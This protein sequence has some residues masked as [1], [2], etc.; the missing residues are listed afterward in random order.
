MHI[1][2]SMEDYWSSISSTDMNVGQQLLDEYI[3]KNPDFTIPSFVA[4]ASQRCADFILSCQYDGTDFNCCDPRYT[5]STMTDL[6]QCYQTN[7]TKLKQ[8]FTVGYQFGASQGLQ[9]LLDFRNDEQIS[10]ANSSENILVKPPFFNLFENGFRIHIHDEMAISFMSTEVISVS[11]NNKIAI[12]LRP[13]KYEFLERSVGGACRSS[14]PNGY[15]QTIPYSETL[16]QARCIALT[17]VSLCGCAPLRFNFLRDKPTCT[18]KELY[19]CVAM[20]FPISYAAHVPQLMPDCQECAPQCRHFVYY[21]HASYARDIPPSTV[22]YLQQFGSRFTPQYVRQNV[23]GMH[24]FFETKK[25][26]L[27]SQ[28]P[29]SDFTNVLSNIGGNMG[30]FLGGSVISLFEMALLT[31]KVGWALISSKRTRYMKS[32]RIK[33]VI[34]ARRKR[35]EEI[36][37]DDSLSMQNSHSSSQITEDTANYE[38]AS[39]SDPQSIYTSNSGKDITDVEELSA[40]NLSMKMINEPRQRSGT[41][42]FLLTPALAEALLYDHLYTGGSIQ[43]DY[44]NNKVGRRFY[45]KLYM[46]RRRYPSN[47]ELYTWSKSVRIKSKQ[48]YSI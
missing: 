20:K 41:L 27:Y 4:N 11:P 32:K 37:S 40:E 35:L 6:G 38:V 44:K 9:M 31:F 28:S 14:W 43:L 25:F 7:L 21:S 42:S 46:G 2:S 24:V 22:Q 10:I 39:T 30:L 17:Y 45:A 34:D 18:P 23:V 5:T 26:V 1:Y 13:T 36:L 16:C 47:K 48:S 29:L 19:D 33:E 8:D 3:L 15:S 12:A